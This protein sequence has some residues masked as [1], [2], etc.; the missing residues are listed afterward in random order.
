MHMSEI[1]QFKQ[2][3]DLQGDYLKYN[4]ENNPFPIGGQS[5]REYPYVNI[6][7]KVHKE[8]LDF[9]NTLTTTKNWQGLPIVGDNGT[10]KTRLLFSLERDIKMQLASANVI[11]INNPPADPIKFFQK[12]IRSC[13]LDE[14]TSLIVNRP[15]NR[16]DFL[17]II[18]K[19]LIF[20]PTLV[21][22]KIPKLENEKV[23]VS[24]ISQRLN[25]LD[26]DPNLRFAYSILIIRY[27]ITD[28]LRE[29]GIE[30]ELGDYWQ[31][32]VEEIKRFIAGEKISSSILAKM[33]ISPIN[34][35]ESYM[36]KIIFPMFLKYNFAAGKSMV[37]ALIDEFQ[38]VIDISSKVKVTSILNM[39]VATSQTNSTGFCMVLSCLPDSW[40]YAGRLSNSFASR[41][42]K[43]LPMPN[44]SKQ[45]ALIMIKEYLNYGRIEK[46]EGVSPFDEDAINMIL[47]ESKYNVREFLKISGAILNIFVAEKNSVSINVN[48]V[49]KIFTSTNKEGNLSI[50]H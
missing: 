30:V 41:F 18:N 17:K 6:S 45:V 8:I 10:G 26:F 9:V 47:Q 37:Y 13:D 5:L 33:G 27:I 34:V 36:E 49:K 14:L 35:D 44:L 31:S 2:E 1:F 40:N 12:I 20:Q 16:S 28:V 4:L 11:Y 19:H 46:N 38:F 23:V 25:S 21:G 3:E 50:W 22:K 42:R 29:E 15:E 39:I 48:F 24:E 43:P 7:E 32:E